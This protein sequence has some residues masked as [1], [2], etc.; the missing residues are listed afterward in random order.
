M[1]IES[2]IGIVAGLL[3][4]AA[5]IGIKFDLIQL[6]KKKPT[7]ELLTRLKRNIFKISDWISVEEKL[8]YL[9]SV[10]VIT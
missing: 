8:C 1:N 5:A 3:T 7:T 2:I 10:I 6:L 4:I 9:I